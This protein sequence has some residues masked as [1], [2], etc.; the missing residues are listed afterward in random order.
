MNRLQRCKITLGFGILLLGLNQPCIGKTLDTSVM[1]SDTTVEQTLSKAQIDSIKRLITL[2]QNK[3]I[4]Q[5]ANKIAF[6][7]NRAYP[8]P[9][10]KNKAE[11][12]QRFIEVFD[13]TL[14]DRIANA[15]L[16]E[17]EEVGWRGIMFDRG[18]FW[19]ANADGVIT[20][21]NYQSDFEKKRK[22][23]LIAEDKEKLY[24]SLK[25]FKSPVYKIE[26]PHYLIRI[27]ELE[28]SK[29]RYASW[30]IGKSEGSQPDLILNNGSLEFDGS[31]G[32][33][34]I[35]F[36]NENYTYFIYRWYI[37]ETE[38]SSD[39]TLEVAK[40]GQTILTED[41]NLLME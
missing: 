11:F 2:F 6:P 3:D 36:T 16:D 18:L 19:M 9:S 39:I 5:I 38:N 13:N 33:H 1:L 25:T 41:G 7:L 17:W 30:K 37:M 40:D 4:D 20:A 28:D 10:I 14:I 15:T 24:P 8:I 23:E 31:G 32:N 22:Q 35:T 21:V 27:D 34:V 26:T 12:K 29:Y